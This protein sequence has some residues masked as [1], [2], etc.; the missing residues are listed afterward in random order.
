MKV[1][2]KREKIIQSAIQVFAEKGFHEAKISEIAENAG[3]ADGTIYIYF[4]NKNDILL[5]II[6]EETAKITTKLKQNLLAL[7]SPEDKLKKFIELY[8]TLFYENKGLATLFQNELRRG[9]ELVKDFH[10]DKLIEYD[11][12]LREIIE[13]GQ[14]KGIFIKDI[15]PSIIV[16]AIYGALDELVRLVVNAEKSLEKDLINDQI[17]KFILNGLKCH[18][19]R[20]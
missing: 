3:V 15:Q 10:S 8:L 5:A 9:R 4:K 20:N 6:E 2:D 16:N 7:D 13:E 12:I 18:R 17:Q 19:S 1:G 11:E 14:K